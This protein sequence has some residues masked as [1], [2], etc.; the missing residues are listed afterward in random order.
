[1]TGYRKSVNCI[2]CSL[3]TSSASQTVFGGWTRAGFN[4]ES[5]LVEGYPCCCQLCRMC[6]FLREKRGGTRRQWWWV[7]EGCKQQYKRFIWV[8]HQYIHILFASIRHPSILQLPWEMHC[9]PPP[10]PPISLVIEYW[11]DVSP[12]LCSSPSLSPP[13]SQLI[14]SYYS[15]QLHRE[16]RGVW[17]L[18]VAQR[19]R[20]DG[21]SGGYFLHAGLENCLAVAEEEPVHARSQESVPLP[22]HP[23]LIWQ[24]VCVCMW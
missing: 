3:L 12:P 13:P 11:V 4:A 22:L 15:A 24:S 2:G 10:P 17:E 1:M 23:V 6:W 9:T 14:R 19:W 20:E 16:G 18:S 7:A 8:V 5:W 21:R